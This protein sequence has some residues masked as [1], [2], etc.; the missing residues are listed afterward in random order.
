MRAHKRRGST[1]DRPKLLFAQACRY[2]RRWTSRRRDAMKL[3]R[4]SE[5]E[6]A[7]RG[8]QTA[9]RRHRQIFVTEAGASWR[10]YDSNLKKIEINAGRSMP[11]LRS[12]H[13]SFIACAAPALH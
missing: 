1:A 2:F 12:R 4:V 9:V 6:S 13:N 5:D 8:S 3:L 11:A 7:S 10:E